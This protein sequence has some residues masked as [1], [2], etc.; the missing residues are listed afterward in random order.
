MEIK[1]Y[2]LE[3]FIELKQRLHVKFELSIIYLGNS[4]SKQD[5]YKSRKWYIM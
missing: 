1:K 3:V 4:C 5:C 2:Y